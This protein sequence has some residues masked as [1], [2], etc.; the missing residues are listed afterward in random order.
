MFK[1]SWHLPSKRGRILQLWQL[2]V[3]FTEV[4]PNWATEEAVADIVTI[5]AVRHNDRRVNPRARHTI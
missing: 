4:S 3:A 1:I 5:K 2:Y